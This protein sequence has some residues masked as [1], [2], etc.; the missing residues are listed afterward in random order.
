M[1]LPGEGGCY[2]LKLQGITTSSIQPPHSA[3]K[4]GRKILTQMTPPHHI[5]GLWLGVRAREGSGLL[6]V[7]LGTKRKKKR[8]LEP[9]SLP[10][11]HRTSPS[12]GLKTSDQV[13]GM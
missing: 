5:K 10:S 6:A 1:E 7:L 4:E 12:Q 3:A 9:L 13:A 2:T 11:S 8:M